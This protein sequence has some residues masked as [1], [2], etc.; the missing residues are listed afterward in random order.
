MSEPETSDVVAYCSVVYEGGDPRITELE[1]QVGML[2]LSPTHIVFGV[3]T[4]EIEEA[5]ANQQPFVVQDLDFRLV[6]PLTSILSHRIENMVQPPTGTLP[7][8]LQ[9]LGLKKQTAERTAFIID[10][11]DSE[12]NTYRSVFSLPT[13]EGRTDPR[14][15]RSLVKLNGALREGIESF[16]SWKEGNLKE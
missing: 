1:N 13:L 4:P 8:I 10:Y 11:A 7:R 15:R 3:L 6:I 14:L 16:L 9:M 5:I 2:V 12:G